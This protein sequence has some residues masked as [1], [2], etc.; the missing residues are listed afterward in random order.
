MV[1]AANAPWLQTPDWSS[2]MSRGASAGA[3]LAGN[4]LRAE[5]I[6][7]QAQQAAAEL[8]YRYAALQSQENRAAAD[9][10]AQKEQATAAAELMAN[11]EANRLAQ[12]EQENA[13][14]KAGLDLEGRPKL[15][16]TENPIVAVDPATGQVKELRPGL[17]KPPSPLRITAPMYP[18]GVDP[19]T[20]AMLG[21][22]PFTVTG[23]QEQIAPL[24][25]TNAPAALR[26]TNAPA[27]TLPQGDSEI[28]VISPDGVEGTI[29]ASQLADALKEGYK[30]K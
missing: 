20:A 12:W 3:E 25:G 2:V 28:V 15:F 30:R 26:G 11:K 24:L 1:S 10:Q 16:S 18:E 7:Q 27:A 9:A 5:Q 8:S 29:P 14:R 6:A 23:T 19:A 21:Q 13:I 4:R 22:K 17:T